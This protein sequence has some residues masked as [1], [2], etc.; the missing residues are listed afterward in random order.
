MPPPVD[1]NIHV[2]L[3]EDNPGD[4]RLVQEAFKEG[5]FSGK[6]HVVRDGEE[7]LAFLHKQGNFQE[8]PRPSF[9]LLD[10]N[11]PR[12]NG[13]EVLAEVKK[14]KEL[15]KIPVFILSTST[16]TADIS[17]AYDMHAN[18]YIP[19]PVELEQLVHL[20]QRLEAF[21]LNSAVL[22]A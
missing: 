3:V 4:V 11:L 10:L 9:V 2:L 22:P 7:A 15:R 1:S 5:G 8:S 12:K 16:S 21:W 6:L 19:K 20:G 17:E 13:Q 18:C 14:E